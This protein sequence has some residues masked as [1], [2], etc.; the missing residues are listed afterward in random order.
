MSLYIYL[1][2][3]LTIIGLAG[4]RCQILPVLS[5]VFNVVEFVENTLVSNFVFSMYGTLEQKAIE[6]SE[7]VLFLS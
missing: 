3:L 2:S 1:F 5:I 4:H 6:R 7:S